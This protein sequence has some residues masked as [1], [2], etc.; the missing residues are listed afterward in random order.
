MMQ[1]LKPGKA[2]RTESSQLDCIVER[3]AGEGAQGEVYRAELAGHTVALKWYFSNAA[4]PEQR[5]SIENLVRKGPPSDRFLWPMELASQRG[6]PGFGYIM[7]F[8]DARFHGLTDLMKRRI[9]PGFRALTTAGFEL[10][11][12][13]LQLHSKG[14]CYRDISFGNLFLDPIG[15]EILICDNDNVA[16]D[17][18]AK[19]GVL[20]TLRFMAP[21]LVRSESLPSIQTDLFSLAI[22]LFYLFMVHHP[23]EGRKEISI[24][25]FDLPAMVRL[26]GTEP[27]FIF[28]PDDRSNEPVSGY[29]DNALES[30]PIYPPFLR[31]LFVRAFTDGIRDP[32]HGRVRESEWRA[33]MARLRDSLLY[34][35]HCGTEN[36]FD[37]AGLTHSPGTAG[38]CWSCEK[39][40]Q[41]P[42][43]VHIG[44]AV[45]LLNHDTLL[46]PHH[47][48]DQK[49]Y[50]FSEPIAAV[51]RHPTQPQLWG[52]KNL[53]E[54][55][56]FYRTTAQCEPIEIPTGRSVPLA[57]G[58][59]I[60]FG[61][62]EGE[63]RL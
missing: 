42:F 43:R 23:L 30:W 16:V 10:A 51:N 34:C 3:L 13:F 52:L 15:G 18:D 49:I 62:S 46:F 1:I 57:E 40:I 41:M 58:T 56:W 47:V 45:I 55:S 4:T 44:R 21:E 39:W 22:L 54:S 53:A 7:R 9:D 60:Q 20:G 11:H 32:A 12:S 8:R 27:V 2:V 36:F 24:H 59:R 35:Q 48:D 50:N 5:A 38:A 17:G 25:S 29:H 6:V 31:E 33:A 37:A 63:I 26:Y 19:A 61:K 28:D 14:L